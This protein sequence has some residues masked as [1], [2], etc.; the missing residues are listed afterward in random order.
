MTVEHLRVQNLEFCPLDRSFLFGPV[1][2][3]VQ[4][5]DCVGIIG[6]SGVGKSTLIELLAGFR[7]P[8]SKS[9]TILVDNQKWVSARE[10]RQ[11]LASNHDFLYPWERNVGLV[12]QKG[13]GLQPEKTVRANLSFGLG[14]LRLRAMNEQSWSEIVETYW[15]RESEERSLSVS[16][17]P[18]D[19]LDRKVQDLSGGQKTR[20]ALARGLAREDRLLY[21]LDEPFEGQ[22]NPLRHELVGLLRERVRGAKLEGRDTAFV[23]VTHNQAEALFVADKLIYLERGSDQRV[24][25]RG[26]GTPRQLTEQPPNLSVARFLGDPPMNLFGGEARDAGEIFIGGRPTGRLV[27]TPP[28]TVL[29]VGMPP[30]DLSEWDESTT[31]LAD[32]L[33]INVRMLDRRFRGYDWLYELEIREPEDMGQQVFLE[34]A[35]LFLQSQRVLSH[36]V[37]RI[38]LPLSRLHVF[39]AN[40]G[41]RLTLGNSGFRREVG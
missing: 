16:G 18:V 23:F 27:N 3:A 10:S 41:A 32:S 40:G 2:L 29:V 17:K 12:L 39:E 9:S 11:W 24:V 21:L 36:D 35:R 15:L 5:G 13:A 20:V 7:R 19:F 1:D 8:T 25:V 4:Q 14:S 38:A 22:D 33:I 30:V 6:H 34:S 31:S 28:G 37:F 26:E